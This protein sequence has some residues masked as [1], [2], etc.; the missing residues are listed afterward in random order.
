VCEGRGATLFAVQ[1]PSQ[2]Q[3][4]R[5][6]EPPE[7]RGVSYISFGASNTLNEHEHMQTNNALKF[8]T[9]RG[10]PTE[11]R[12][13]V[14]RSKY[15]VGSENTGCSKGKGAMTSIRD[16]KGTPVR[17]LTRPQ[18][19]GSFTTANGTMSSLPNRLACTHAS[20]D[21]DN[22]R[23]YTTN[24]GH[25]ATPEGPGFGGR[26]SRLP[27]AAASPFAPEGGK[28]SK[29]KPKK[30]RLPF[31]LPESHSAP[32]LARNDS[33]RLDTS[34]APSCATVNGARSSAVAD[35]HT[36]QRRRELQRSWI[37]DAR[38]PDTPL[39]SA[40]GVWSSSGAAKASVG[41]A[42]VKIT[43]KWF[44]YASPHPN[45]CVEQV[46]NPGRSLN[47]RSRAL[48]HERIPRDAAMLLH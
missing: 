40:T 11:M 42:H 37:R 5:G 34:A 9:Q 18:T 8:E 10:P 28:S 1:S 35:R 43:G 3:L 2:P 26:S 30:Q 12:P 38:E 25:T 16:M 44:G 4:V 15:M 6:P 13:Y 48:K 24:N 33:S 41:P 27:V 21:F 31:D 47:K 45:K 29:S 17:A 20:L 36:G 22:S 46:V 19:T 14:F 23:M 7:K 32:R 39:H